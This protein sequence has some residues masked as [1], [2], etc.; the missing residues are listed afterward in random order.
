MPTWPKSFIYSNLRLAN[1]FGPLS[2]LGYSSDRTG[3]LLSTT[4]HSFQMQTLRFA[5]DLCLTPSYCS[6]N[7]KEM[8]RISLQD[9]PLIKY[10]KVKWNYARFR[11]MLLT[12][13]PMVHARGHE[14]TQSGHSGHRGTPRPRARSPARHGSQDSCLCT[15]VT[16]G[17]GRLFLL[18]ERIRSTPFWVFWMALQQSGKRA[19]DMKT[20]SRP[21]KGSIRWETP[22]PCS[23]PQKWEQF[24]KL[25]AI[26]SV[27]LLI[28]LR[29]IQRSVG[30]ES[31]S[32]VQWL[33]MIEGLLKSMLVIF[34]FPG[35]SGR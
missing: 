21:A 17:Y 18:G 6:W 16:Y 11:S 10:D 12:A 23:P 29:M 9:L 31:M 15:P 7:C 1:I 27:C 22:R 3:C 13:A 25:S 5:E 14:S 30:Q 20:T 4:P 2:Q 26:K 24:K 19:S 35:F 28:W 33:V 32:H 8:K 34:P